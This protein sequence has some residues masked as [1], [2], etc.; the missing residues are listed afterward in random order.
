MCVRDGAGTDIEVWV[1]VL[2]E[3]PSVVSPA[4]ACSVPGEGKKGH[5]LLCFLYGL[6]DKCF[7]KPPSHGSQQ[8]KQ[9]CR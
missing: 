1:V 4:K 9:E 3:R 6:P 7:A 8:E 2:E 5:H